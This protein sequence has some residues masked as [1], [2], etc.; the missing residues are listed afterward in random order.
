M[1]WPGGF[2]ILDGVHR[3]SFLLS[4]GGNCTLTVSCVGDDGDDRWR[5][6]LYEHC[7]GWP[8]VKGICA[9]IEKKA[10]HIFSMAALHNVKSVK[11]T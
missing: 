5:K 2:F 4:L 1:R 3:A 7:S 10:G 6:G 9:N 8:K 11:P